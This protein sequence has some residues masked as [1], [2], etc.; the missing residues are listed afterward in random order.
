MAGDLVEEN[1]NTQHS[2]ATEDSKKEKPSSEESEPQYIFKDS[3]QD[4]DFLS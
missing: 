3:M 2:E 4:Q 1:D